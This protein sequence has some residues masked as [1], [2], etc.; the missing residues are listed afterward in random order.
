MKLLSVIVPVYNEE[1]MVPR[2][3]AVISDILDKAKIDYEI[4]FV[5]DGSK[6]MSWPAIAK[7]CDANPKVVGKKPQCL[8][9]L[10]MREGGA[11]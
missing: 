11:Q 5:N 10:K 2:T 6:D 3:A 7:E 8:P 4:I 9:G 1:K